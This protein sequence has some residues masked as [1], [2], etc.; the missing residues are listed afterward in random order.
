M[1]TAIEQ[2]IVARL[3]DGLGHLVQSIKSY[4][5]ELED[6][7]NSTLR[8]PALWVTY[9]GGRIKP[10]DTRRLR[11]Q[12]TDKFVVIVA[13]KSLR[14]EQTRRQG[15]VTKW[16]IG[17]NDLIDAVIRLMSSQTLDGKLTSFGMTPTDIKAIFNNALTGGTAVSA[18]AVEFDCAYDRKALEDG[19]MPEPVADTSDP[20]YVFTD[21]EGRLS[22]P[23]PDLKTIQ[24][25]VY[26][27]TSDASIGNQVT[28][29]E[30]KP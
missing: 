3:T 4:G 14:N 17:T 15:G 28:F 25:K 7:G 11:Y 6:M 16:E 13:T 24:G 1:L 23:Y 5:G 30:K 22:E 2:A 21:Y 8:F 27:P 12:N 9:G 10:M 20:D 19:R 29:G 18:Y 26:D